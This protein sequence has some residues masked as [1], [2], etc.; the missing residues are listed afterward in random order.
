MDAKAPV[1][2]AYMLWNKIRRYSSL[3]ARYASAVI[4]AQIEADDKHERGQPQEPHGRHGT[5]EDA[6]LGAHHDRA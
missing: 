6:Y 5:G 3:I 4:M 1:E 2:K